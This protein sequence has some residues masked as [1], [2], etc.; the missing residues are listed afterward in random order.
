MSEKL[1]EKFCAE[2]QGM[3]GHTHQPNTSAASQFQVEDSKVIP[4]KRKHPKII[5]HVTEGFKRQN[6]F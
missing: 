1:E 4:N 6:G 2:A 3:A 5:Y